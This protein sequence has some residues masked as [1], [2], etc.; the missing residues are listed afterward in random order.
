MGDSKAIPFYAKF[1]FA[2][3]SGVVSTVICYPLEL[4]KNRM[5]VYGKF[6]KGHPTA[7]NFMKIIVKQN[8]I[9]GLY[10]G[11]GASVVRQTLYTGTR[12]GLYQAWLDYINNTYGSPNL[13]GMCGLAIVSGAMGG[14]AGLP[15][16]VALTRITTD[17]LLPSDKRRN[18]KNVTDAITRMYKEEG[19]S[20]LFLGFTSVVVRAVILN[21]SQILSYY[22][23]K[24]VVLRFGL[25]D[26]NT[27][28]HISCSMVS[29]LLTTYIVLPMDVA[30]TRLQSMQVI[31]G[32]P[33]YSS[34]RHVLKSI[35]MKE[36]FTALWSGIGP[37]VIRNGPQFFIIFLAYEQ[38]VNFY[39]KYR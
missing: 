32:K 12:M 29:A 4:V 7:F 1:L 16:D 14:I 19:P 35:I 38:C 37:L 39:Q 6:G 17:E 5:Q 24:Q 15:A 23:I 20:T 25:V 33:E 26:D 10:K 22:Y 28:A 21:T 30:K 18:Y 9:L 3:T 8:G 34:F 11:C 13:L 36:G 31:N 27:S 2:G